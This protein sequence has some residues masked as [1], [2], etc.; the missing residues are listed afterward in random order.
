MDTN[1]IVCIKHTATFEFINITRVHISN[2]KFLGCGGNR[3]E[4]VMHFTL[5]NTTFDGQQMRNQYV[6]TAL[7]LVNSSLTAKRSS[8]IYSIDGGAV[9]V[10]E[11]NATFLN[12]N[13]EGNRAEFGGAIWKSVE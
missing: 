7:E 12:C 13:F 11:S 4:L 8:F 5:I 3:V 6:G 1:N 9:I 10:N 2:I